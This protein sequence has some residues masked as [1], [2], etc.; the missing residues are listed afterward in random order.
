MRYGI[1]WCDDFYLNNRLFDK[2]DPISNRDDCL[3][4]WWVLRE[5]FR[6]RGIEL[7]TQDKC[8]EKPEFILFN[9]MPNMSL[10]VIGYI[11]CYLIIWESEIIKP[12]NWNKA[13]HKYFDR[14]FSWFHWWDEPEYI[15]IKHP[16]QIRQSSQSFPCYPFPQL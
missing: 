10:P 4:H 8:P 3:Y 12:E 9:D 5:E 13:N 15:L 7:V 1:V 2:D 6:K 16:L 11:P 14:I